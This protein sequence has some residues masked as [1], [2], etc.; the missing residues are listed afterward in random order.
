M[1]KEM[2]YTEKELR[3]ER[4][5]NNALERYDVEYTQTLARLSENKVRLNNAIDWLNQQAC[6]ESLSNES[7]EPFFQVVGSTF[8]ID[9][10]HFI[11]TEYSLCNNEHY[12]TLNPIDIADVPEHGET[13]TIEF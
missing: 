5:K 10:I 2:S 9:D 1:S 7:F 3:L 12:F 6:F 11:C 8:I 4:L 13:K